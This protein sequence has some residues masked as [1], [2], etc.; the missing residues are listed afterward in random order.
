MMEGYE[1][2]QVI[3]GILL[4]VCMGL[5]GAL[6]K[7]LKDAHK[8]TKDDVSNLFK[9]VSKQ[10]LQM[11]DTLQLA[12]LNQLSIEKNQDLMKMHFEQKGVHN[13]FAER[14]AKLEGRSEGPPN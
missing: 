8:E 2:M 10:Q 13:D 11:S 4:L 3:N 12:K 1:V 6:W 7:S 14:V 9:L 5:A